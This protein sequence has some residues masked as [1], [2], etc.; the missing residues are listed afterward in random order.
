MLMTRDASSID[1]TKQR[2]YIPSVPTWDDL[3]ETFRPGR[4]LVVS[5]SAGTKK[6]PGGIAA[7]S[8]SLSLRAPVLLHNQPKPGC[9]RSIVQYFTGQL[10]EPTTRRKEIRESAKQVWREEKE[11][12]QALWAR[13]EGEVDGP[14]LGQLGADLHLSK[15]KGREGD[16]DATLEKRVSKSGASSDSGVSAA[17][18]S[19]STSKGK[20]QVDDLRILV[21]GDRLFT[22]TLLAHRLSLYLPKPKH[23]SN[24]SAS[25]PETTTAS[26][27]SSL[28]SVLSIHTTALPQPK[29][30]R[31]LR[32]VEEKLTRGQLRARPDPNATGG[33][34]ERLDLSRFVLAEP[35]T[36]PEGNSTS[37]SI[38]A[39]RSLLS[40]RFAWMRWFT[41]S[42]WQELDATT[43]PLTYHPR[44]WKPLPIT[45]ALT[46]VFSASVGMLYRFGRR[47]IRVSWVKGKE[48]LNKR[49]R[50]RL[51]E[52][53][54]SES[55]GPGLGQRETSVVLDNVREKTA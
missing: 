5:N 28:P 3:L 42:R 50:Q 46:K 48:W 9:S 24:N 52:P 34:S 21:I 31:L 49:R 27:S 51:V 1:I 25:Q 30:V 2:R 11:D 13:W 4:V 53:P 44:S 26:H 18:V 32:W 16:K 38:V 20:E 22:D 41:P 6:D 33:G 36:S 45:I 8:V 40:G 47:G 37:N 43:P 23:K 39:K 55:V 35:E 7:E 19:E 12:E 14:L 29:D 10:G 17:R 54:V 15:M